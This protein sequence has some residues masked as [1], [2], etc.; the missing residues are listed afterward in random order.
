MAE[1]DGVVSSVPRRLGGRI[2]THEGSDGAESRFGQV[3][4]EVAEGISVVGKAM[5]TKSKWA[6][7]HLEVM[8]IEAVCLDRT[9]LE[10]GH[11]P[12][13]RTSRLGGMLRK[14]P[15]RVNAVGHAEIR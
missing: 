13:G 8:E 5:H 2:A 1:Q 4:K 9:R 10:L 11:H 12:S 7:A 3:R 15:V 6:L 14:G